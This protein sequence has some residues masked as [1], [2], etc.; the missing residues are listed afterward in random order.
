MNGTGLNGRSS[1][2]KVT[3][4]TGEVLQ[5]RAV[6]SDHFG[7]GITIWKSDLIELIWR[8]QIAFV[9]DRTTFEP[10]RTFTY[11]GEGWGLTHDGGHLTMSDRSATLRFLDPATF[12]ERLTVTVTDA[13]SPVPFLNE[14]EYVKGEIFANVWQTDFVARVAPSTGKVVGWVD[15]RGCQ[16]VIPTGSHPT[17]SSMASPT[18]RP[19]V[20]SS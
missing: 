6:S 15:L 17:P 11:L 19:A 8:S 18:T 4:E 1:I 3:L 20:G 2:R 14:L 16:V 10:K 9:Y 5:Q 12:A 7:E 13:G